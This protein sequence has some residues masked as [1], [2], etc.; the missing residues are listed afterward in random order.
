M[1]APTQLSVR[2]IFRIGIGPS[3]SHT[4]GP[5]LAGADFAKYIGGAFTDPAA[6]TITV[7]LLGS[8]GAT[9]R[10]H[11]SDRAVVMGLAGFAPE[12]VPAD[13]VVGLR[14]RFMTAGS[15]DVPGVGAVPFGPE[16]IRFLSGVRLP[17]CANGMVITAVAGERRISRT[18]YSI[19]GGFLQ[20]SDGDARVSPGLPVWSQAMSDD[21]EVAVP[22][23]FTTAEKLLEQCTR[24]GKSISEVVR[25]NELA[26]M[27]RTEL[28]AYLDRVWATMSECINAGCSTDGFLPGTLRVRRRAKDS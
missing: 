12:T 4:V 6:V 3:S 8:L 26:R 19:G 17:H 11:A 27:S 13:V 28:E 25:A 20:L 23:P 5:M 15:L 21:V 16:S 24:S 9:G 10:G 7:D 22:Y 1:S 18:Y 14:D 2:D